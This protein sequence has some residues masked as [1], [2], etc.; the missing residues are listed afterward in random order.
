MNK[1]DRKTVS[2]KEFTEQVAE[3]LELHTTRAVKLVDTFLDLMVENLESK[4]KL[5]FRGYFI[6]G[7]KVT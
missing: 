3:R 5:E 2:R 7:T 6:L 4:R 1:A